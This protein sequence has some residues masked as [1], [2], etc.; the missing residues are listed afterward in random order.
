VRSFSRGMQQRLALAGAVLARPKILL[1]DEPHSGLDTDSMAILDEQ[2]RRLLKQGTAILMATHDLRS[3]KSLASRLDVLV[4]GR[5]TASL[6]PKQL[7][8]GSWEKTYERVLRSAGG[9]A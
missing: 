1:L 8:A 5:L 7:G 3:A 4:G 6:T 9:E 2:L